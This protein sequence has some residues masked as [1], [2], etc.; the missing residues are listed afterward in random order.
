M[1]LLM[2]MFPAYIARIAA[3]RRGSASR[4]TSLSFNLYP[5]ISL[6]CIRGTERG[7]PGQLAAA[8]TP[9]TPRPRRPPRGGVG[10]AAKGGEPGQGDPDPPGA[11]VTRRFL[12]VPADVLMRE[13]LRLALCGAPP[14]AEAADQRD[15]HPVVGGRDRALVA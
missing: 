9:P 5:Q 11:V 12:G 7:R 15:A 1:P 13:A 2:F 10:G 3:S 6:R 14:L 8:A 4:E